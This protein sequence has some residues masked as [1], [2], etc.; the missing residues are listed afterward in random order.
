DFLV[1]VR[2]VSVICTLQDLRKNRTDFKQFSRGLLGLRGWSEC[3]RHW[4][5]KSSG[6]PRNPGNPRLDKSLHGRLVLWGRAQP[7]QEKGPGTALL[8]L[9]VQTTES[10]QAA[11]AGAR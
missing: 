9:C 11:S 7:H 8:Y 10:T 5:R 6:N 4:R 1:P 2:V 3:W